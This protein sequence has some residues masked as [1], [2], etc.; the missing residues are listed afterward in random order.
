VLVSSNHLVPLLVKTAL[1]GLSKHFAPDHL[2]SSD[3]FGP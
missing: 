1:F 3:R 2:Y